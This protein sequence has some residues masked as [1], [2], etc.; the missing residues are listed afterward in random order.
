MEAH[1][2]ARTKSPA[3]TAQADEKQSFQERETPAAGMAATAAPGQAPAVPQFASTRLAEALVIVILFLIAASAT[4]SFSGCVSQEVLDV[5]KM[6]I[7]HVDLAAVPD[8]TFRGD[9]TYGDFTY[10]VEVT[11]SDHTITGIDI[12]ANRDTPHAVKAAGVLGNVI[13]EQR[14][15]VDVVAGAT[16]TSKALLKAVENALTG[17]RRS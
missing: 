16:S 9:F 6:P 3:R 12:V 11:V 10:I 5:R 8:G 4:I 7:E 2:D 14:T 15:D 1:D 13:L 17:L